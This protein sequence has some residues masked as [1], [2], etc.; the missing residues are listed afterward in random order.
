MNVTP[1]K[2]RLRVSPSSFFSIKF[3]QIN[4]WCRFAPLLLLLSS[5]LTGL[6]SAAT[7]NVPYIHSGAITQDNLGFIWLATRN[8]LVRHDSENDIIISNN[9]KNWPLPFNWINDIEVIENN[10]LLV[11]TETHKLWVFDT[12]TGEATEI[13][14]DIHHN[15]VYQVTA[16]HGMYYLNVH[17]KLYRI[18]P[19][20][21]VTE[22]IAD[23]VEISFLEHTKEHVYIATADG[24]FKV[25]D[26]N[27]E[28]VT[29]G[30]ISAMS[31]S[32]SSLVIAK[33]NQLITLSDNNKRNSIIVNSTLTALTAS[34]DMQSII[35][36]DNLGE[37]HKYQLSD[38][39]TLSHN[40]PKIKPARV[41]TIY[42]DSTGVL[43]LLSNHGIE[44]V[45]R[46]SA[47]N[48]PK[49]FDVDI[50][51]IALAMHKN[52]LILGSYGAGLSTLSKTSQL[53]PA[54]INQNF[55]AKAKFI[56]DVYA[57]DS[58]IYVATFDGLWQ[59]D[60]IK[61]TLERV[62]FA[63]NNLLLLSMRYKDG[64]LYLATN[65]NG[66]VKYNLASKQL[67]YYVEGELLTSPEV[68]DILPLADNVL[69]AATSVGIDIID[70]D[71]NI[72]TPIK[73]FSEAKVISLLEYQGKVF[74]STNGD[75]LFI[76]NMEGELLSHIAKKIVFGYM[77]YIDNEIWIAA[78]PGLY[79]LN[80]DTYQLTLVPN[81]EQYSFSKKQALL[82]D[83]VY[84][85]HYSGILEVPLTNENSIDAKIHISKTTVSGRTQL[86]N[87]TINI[88]SPNDVVTLELASLDF[89]TGQKKKFKYQ[90]N[91]KDW[92]NTNGSQLTLTGLSAGEYNIEIMGTN[93]LGE[94]SK[95]KAYADINVAYPWYAH[96]KSQ[97]IYIVLVVLS[98][99]YACWLLYLRSRSIHHVHQLLNNEIENQ[100][101]SKSNIRRKLLKVQS[102]INEQCPEQSKATLIEKAQIE[103]SRIDDPKTE[104]ESHET[105]SSAND[106]S[107]RT[108][109]S[110]INECL[111]DLTSKKPEIVPNKLS[112]STLSIALPYLVDYFH[113]Q[114]HVLIKLELDVEDDRIDHAMQTV[115][116]RIIYEAI[117]AAIKNGNG[118]IF[119]VNI[120]IANNKIWLRITDNEQSFAQFSSKINFD[121]AMY[122]IRQV[123]KKFN[124]TFHTY[125][126]QERG[127]EMILS[128]PLEKFS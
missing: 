4:Q 12:T 31:A 3:K 119:V 16:H 107:I 58:N 19:L 110:L 5:F 22:V 61:K 125:D 105:K 72:I 21:Q 14:V 98:A 103:D 102:L 23:D 84:A 77:S 57:D 87:K 80:P 85:S 68:I 127:S 97:V 93:S 48:I 70:T 38:L 78:R 42:H 88:D 76:F 55:T 49:I 35:A 95:Y 71:K 17:Y 50:N 32:E 114:Y 89:R 62:P 60:S 20:T 43:W 92:N 6:S 113:K 59:F 115:I 121:M 18:N 73:R 26:S 75:G 52:Q 116:Y 29:V 83:K 108:I 124:A 104:I 45:M 86:L 94:W 64:A 8:G 36:V 128:I 9:N 1:Q 33:G 54:E 53:I 24:V 69:W 47:K 51:A 40:Y 11:A 81:T 79:R 44:K 101:Q 41:E 25:V 34:H 10:K 96:P 90:I 2:K 117:S 37:I 99:A 30:P 39:T 111:N 118:G 46:S 109:Q 13:P 74:A 65:A 56:T 100:S 106:K 66:L 82:N 28:Q 7:L 126:N 120:H 63:N 122:Y 91:G 123:A 27:L 67:D 15:S 112:E